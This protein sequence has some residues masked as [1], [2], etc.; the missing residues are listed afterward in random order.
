MTTF[1]PLL[2]LGLTVQYVLRHSWGLVGASTADG[3]EVTDTSNFF[4]GFFFFFFFFFV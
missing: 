2:R 4:E 3:N 1:R